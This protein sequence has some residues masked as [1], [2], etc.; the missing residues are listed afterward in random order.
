MSL[1]VAR[2]I[3]WLSAALAACCL[4]PSVASAQ[5]NPNGVIPIHTSNQPFLFL[6]RDPVVHQAAKLT[7]AQRSRL[8]VLN[9]RLDPAL[10]SMRNK[11]PQ[12][13]AKV[14]A[15]VEKQTK[16]ALAKILRPEQ[17]TRIQ[18]AE[19]WVLGVK[20]LLRDEV[21]SHVKVSA[22]QLAQIR[23]IIVT[24]EKQLTEIQQQA[25]S[26]GELEALNEKWG[27]IKHQQRKDA[28]AVLSDEQQQT[29]R[30]MLGDQIE[31]GRLGRIKMK[32]P[33]FDSDGKWVNSEP[34]TLEKLKGKVVAL[35]FYAFA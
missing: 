34:L 33:D 18:Q 24:A 15:D 17:I 28:I 21:V 30:A 35:H 2:W 29:F 11:G 25:L 1:P 6:V 26:G 12:Q 4:T 8:T 10:W 22:E 14:M 9:N 20:S 27:E 31:A 16:A 5:Q 32:V 13:I 19:Y 23:K 3:W 7:Q